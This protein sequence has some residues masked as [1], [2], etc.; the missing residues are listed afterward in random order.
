MITVAAILLLLADATA[1]A[2]MLAWRPVLDNPDH[3]RQRHADELL[4][5]A[6]HRALAD[7]SNTSHAD[8]AA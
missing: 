1:I 4:W 3:Y 5:Y 2:L 8:E 7:E 6:W